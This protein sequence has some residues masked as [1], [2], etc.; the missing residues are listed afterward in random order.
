[1]LI[2]TGSVHDSELLSAFLTRRELTHA[3]LNARQDKLEADIIGCA[4][5]RGQITV[6]TNMAGRGTDIKLGPSVAELGGLYVISTHCHEE[7]RVD[8]QLIGRCARQ[9]DPGSSETHVSLDDSLLTDFYS[10]RLL[11]WLDQKL[12][13]GDK[14]PQ[15]L[16]TRLVRLPQLAISRQHRLER[17]DVMNLHEKLG[18]VLAYSGQPE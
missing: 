12:K 14:L 11:N 15:W 10:P 9:G 8:R 5:E 3:V 16:A 2:G 6:A 13:R 18:K 4:G 7:R 1:M 17:L